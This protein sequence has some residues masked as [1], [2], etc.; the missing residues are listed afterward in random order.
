MTENQDAK[1]LQCLTMAELWYTIVSLTIGAPI[2]SNIPIATDVRRV[3]LEAFAKA[4]VKGHGK[5]E[6][7]ISEE[8]GT[9][10]LYAG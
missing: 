3:E 9:T 5:R 6:K 8:P 10:Y 4:P 7:S 1:Q 2:P